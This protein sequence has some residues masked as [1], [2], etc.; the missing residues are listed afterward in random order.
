MTHCFHLRLGH[1]NERLFAALQQSNKNRGK[2]NDSQM[3]Q[4]GKVVM[5]NILVVIEQLIDFGGGDGDRESRM[6]RKGD[7]LNSKVSQV[8]K[9]DG[10]GLRKGRFADGERLP[11]SFIRHHV[12]QNPDLEFLQAVAI[13][14]L[15]PNHIIVERDEIGVEIESFQDEISAMFAC[16][17]H[18][19]CALCH[20]V[21]M[22]DCS[23]DVLK[24]FTTIV[25]RGRPLRPGTKAHLFV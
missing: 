11:S 7:D 25:D 17:Q 23:L 8:R 24:S 1:T 5:R 10:R 21:L 13:L 2:R 3:L 16:H 22:I 12:G 9:G 18:Y 14:E 6:L 15:I 19:R 20:L 4:F